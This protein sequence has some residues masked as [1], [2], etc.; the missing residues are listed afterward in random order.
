MVNLHIQLTI[1]TIVSI[2]N[3]IHYRNVSV[4]N[5]SPID[6]VYASLQIPN[7][8]MNCLFASVLIQIAPQLKN[9]TPM[10]LHLQLIN[11]MALRPKDYF[12]NKLS[13]ILL[14]YQKIFIFFNRSSAT[15]FNLQELKVN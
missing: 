8:A 7:D 12:V 13:I 15:Y 5:F 10:D 1:K 14:I 11:E 9:Y 4:I 6:P 2:V 3:N